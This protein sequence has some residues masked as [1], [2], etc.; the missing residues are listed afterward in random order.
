VKQELGVFA[1]E[2]QVLKD[3]ESHHDLK[4]AQSLYGN[5]NYLWRDTNTLKWD[6]S[7]QKEWPPS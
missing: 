6:V 2:R 7:S 5:Q 1:R 3:G 4:E